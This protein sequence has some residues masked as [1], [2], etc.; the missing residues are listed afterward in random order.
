MYVNSYVSS[1]WDDI[2]SNPH[3]QRS[4]KMCNK[5]FDV[6]E[7]AAESKDKCVI[8]MN[9]LDKWWGGFRR[10]IQYVRVVNRRMRHLQVFQ[11]SG[12]AEY[13]VL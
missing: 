7:G 2:R 5:F 6:T 4:D 9:A 8:V 11:V 10:V 13:W 12:R 3:A 1:N